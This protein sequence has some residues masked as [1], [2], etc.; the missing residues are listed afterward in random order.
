[1]RCDETGQLSFHCQG[2]VVA[3]PGGKSVEDKLVYEY[4]HR[5]LNPGQRR[6]KPGRTARSLR[7][8]A[9]PRTWCF[10]VGHTQPLV[11]FSVNG[12]S[13]LAASTL[14]ARNR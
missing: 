14:A 3:V 6:L 5:C 13:S 4:I 2:D 12:F 1:M 9:L 7:F 8:R 10:V 11:S